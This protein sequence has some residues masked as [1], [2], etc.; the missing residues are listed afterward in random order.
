MLLQEKRNKDKGLSNF[1][2]EFCLW[3]L[4][5][6]V[7]VTHNPFAVDE[8][9]V[10]KWKRKIDLCE[11]LAR[12]VD[13]R[14]TNGLF[15][16]IERLPT[17]GPEIMMYSVLRNFGKLVRV[18][19]NL[20]ESNVARMPQQELDAALQ[21]LKDESVPI[22]DVLKKDLLS[23]R[24]NALMEAGKYRELLSAMN[25]YLPMSEFDLFHPTL[26]GLAAEQPAKVSTWNERRETHGLVACKGT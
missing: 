15:K 16:A 13:G 2:G 25:P 8:R 5:A 6:G 1:L 7:C 17:K 3:H 20:G 10:D 4:G 9:D 23:R 26:S 18:C 19:K 12:E 24:C 11:L 14:T 22:P 21:V